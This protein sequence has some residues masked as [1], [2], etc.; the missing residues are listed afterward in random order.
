MSAWIVTKAHID[1]MVRLAV[2]GPVDGEGRWD[3]WGYEKSTWDIS[4][5]G[6][7][8]TDPLDNLGQALWA[9][10]HESVNHRY[11]EQDECPKYEYPGAGRSR[12]LTLAEAFK[13]I[14]CYEY[15]SCEHPAWE[16][17]K[18]RAFCRRLQDSLIG[19]VPGY[20][21]APWGIHSHTAPDG[22]AGGDGAVRITSLI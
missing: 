11:S 12:P 18:A 14:G 13:A 1:A 8:Y 6:N 16:A 15:Q 10:N 9:E 17:S 20:D 19:H 4:V 2:E 7:L 3:F 5:P 22:P 21:A